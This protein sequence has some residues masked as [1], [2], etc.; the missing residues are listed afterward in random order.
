[1]RTSSHST[2]YIRGVQGFCSP[3][4]RRQYSSATLLRLCSKQLL[5]SHVLSPCVSRSIQA[6]RPP[7][8]HWSMTQVGKWCGRQT[9]AIV[10]RRSPKPSLLV[11]G[12]AEAEDRDTR[13]I[14]SRALRTAATNVRGGCRQAWRVGSATLKPGCGV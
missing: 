6:A 7:G 8:W 10:G 3:R 5:S 11:E 2:R 14:E 13:D 12:C 1:M 4:G 9:S